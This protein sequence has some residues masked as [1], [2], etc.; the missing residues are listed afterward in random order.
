M[1]LKMTGRMGRN[2]RLGDQFNPLILAAPWI[3]LQSLHRMSVAD[4]KWKGKS[5]GGDETSVH[6]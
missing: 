2:L 6:Y 1:G 5:Y 4:S 3:G